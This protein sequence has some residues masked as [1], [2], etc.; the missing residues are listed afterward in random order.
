MSPDETT[1]SFYLDIEDELTANESYG[2]CFS[3]DEADT[4]IKKH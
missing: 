3:M 2:C 4:L 1:T